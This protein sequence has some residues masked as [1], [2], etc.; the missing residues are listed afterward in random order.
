MR[1]TVF[2]VGAIGGHL[3][4]RLC[5]APVAEVSVVARGAQL[6]ALRAQGLRLLSPA[7]DVQARPLAAV[8][9]AGALP[10]Q[11]LVFVTLKAP[12]LP[13]AAA[14]IAGLLAPEGCAVF[15]VNGLPWWMGQ[16][17]RSRLDPESRLR[18][19]IGLSRTV[20]GVVYSANAVETPGV[21]RH[22]GYD[23]WAVGETGGEASPRVERIRQL[24]AAAGLA[25][26]ASGDI[27]RE[28]WLKLVHNASTNPLSAL[29]RLTPRDLCIHPDLA[30][31]ALQIRRE[32]A[33]IAAAEG[34]SLAAEPALSSL[35]D[36]A[37]PEPIRP[38]ML[39]DVLSGRALEVEAI[40]GEPTELARR[41]GIAAP[42][43]EA[44]LPLL[45]GLDQSVRA[46]TAAG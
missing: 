42:G 8:E 21:I 26:V 34:C 46:G 24:L 1:V 36:M 40:L 33:A 14:A 45:R 15:F 25:A 13:G 10:P 37:R 12:S 23:R 11:D 44:L 19:L 20:G 7:G 2:G 9:D 38:S 3:A 28:I 22:L 18:D 6:A 41:Y 31:L 43:L 16:A 4:A 29:T 30:P 39:Q 5:H 32:I 27:R 35:A 17:G